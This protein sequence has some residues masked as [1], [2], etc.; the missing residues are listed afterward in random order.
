MQASSPAKER[1]SLYQ[2]EW[3]PF[4]IRVRRVIDQLGIDVE[5]RDTFDP[6]WRSELIAA[7]GR[8]TVPVLRRDTPDG[9]SHWLPES[10]DIIAYL[11]EHYG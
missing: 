9:Q 2:T 3:C 11:R 6:R 7:R 10:V 4:C 1:L 8:G 5:I